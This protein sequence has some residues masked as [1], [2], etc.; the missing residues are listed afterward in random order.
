MLEPPT[1][2]GEPFSTQE[3]DENKETPGDFETVC[4]SLVERGWKIMPKKGT[5]PINK[6]GPRYINL[7]DPRGNRKSVRVTHENLWEKLRAA[8]TRR[9]TRKDESAEN[10]YQAEIA[11]VVNDNSKDVGSLENS[12][13]VESTAAPQYEQVSKNSANVTQS[14]NESLVEG[15]QP[16]V[17]AENASKPEFENLVVET[18]ETRVEESSVLPVQKQ[19]VEAKQAEIVE[20][21]PRELQSFAFSSPGLQKSIFDLG[22]ETLLSA[23]QNETLTPTEIVTKIQEW[24]MESKNLLEFVHKYQEKTLMRTALPDTS[25]KDELITELQATLKE[26]EDK[27]AETLKALSEM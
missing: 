12:S 20:N 21:P 26:T 25:E 19:E 1:P 23:L 5:Y 14:S 3:V 4:I 11:P 22:F 2:A 8:E 15:A 13:I 6:K 16:V 17:T 9:T 27:L 7:V 18:E 10:P 24:S